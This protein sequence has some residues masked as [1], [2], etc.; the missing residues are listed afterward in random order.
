MSVQATTW[1]W[2][3]SKTT[4]STKMVLLAIADHAWPDG[5]NAWPS[6]SRLARMTGLSEDT[7]RRSVNRAEKCGELAVVRKTGGR[8]PKGQHA[9][10]DY[11]LC[12][13]EPNDPPANTAN[14]SQA[15]PS[16]EATPKSLPALGLTPAPRDPNRKVT[17]KEPDRLKSEADLVCRGWWDTSDPKPMPAGGFIGAR[18]IIEKALSAGWLSEELAEVLP[19]VETLAFWSLEKALKQNRKQLV[20]QTKQ[21]DKAWW[22]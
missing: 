7:V 19:T 16:Q 2:N 8:A 6:V 15:L 1:V 14:P 11:V 20:S 3:N 10:N 22:D 13:K 4:G 18:K 9:S 12:M 21:K 5:T 17:Q